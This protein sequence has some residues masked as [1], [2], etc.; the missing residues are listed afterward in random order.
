[1]SLFRNACK[2][3]LLL[4]SVERIFNFKDKMDIIDN[5]NSL[6]VIFCFEK[7]F[8]N[9]NLDDSPQNH[10]DGLFSTDYCKL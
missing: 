9:T 10:N 2:V 1:M 3:V 4:L 8:L 5:I 7:N 6:I